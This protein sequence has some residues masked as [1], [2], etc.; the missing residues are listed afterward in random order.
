VLYRGN[1]VAKLKQVYV[2][3]LYIFLFVRSS[4]SCYRKRQ[5]SLFYCPPQVLGSITRHVDFSIIKCL[6]LA[7]PGFTKDQFRTYM[8]AETVKQGIKVL[9]ENR[10]KIITAHANSAFK[11]ERGDFI[12]FFLSF[13]RTLLS[14]LFVSGTQTLYSSHLLLLI[15]VIPI[16]QQAP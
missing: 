11:G 6:V 3:V 14:L 4:L 7:G 12:F 8:D 5:I 15:S 10:A 9:I 16:F 2:T 13:L 1:G